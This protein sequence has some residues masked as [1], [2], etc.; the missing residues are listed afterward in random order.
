MAS[1]APLTLGINSD[2]S[3]HWHNHFFRAGVDLTRLLESESFFL[4][5]R[6]DP[7]V[8]PAFSGSILV[9]QAGLYAQDHFTLFRNLTVDL[10]LRYD[11]F[12]L[13][14]RQLEVPLLKAHRDGSSRRS[15]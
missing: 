1:R 13:V 11:Y 7:D 9:G 5:G 3:Y 15:A 8:F 6:G 4:D 10:G 12:D 14:G 2:L